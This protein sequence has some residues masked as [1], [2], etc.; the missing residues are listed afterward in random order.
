MSVTVETIA[1][2]S[3]V[4]ASRRKPSPRSI[5]K[6]WRRFVSAAT[7]SAVIG[8]GLQPARCQ[9]AMPIN[10]SETQRRRFTTGSRMEMVHS[11]NKPG[12]A[13]GKRAVCH[14]N[15]VSSAMAMRVRM[16]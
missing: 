2:P 12:G 11:S 5:G 6:V 9:K 1:W 15:V 4:T 8:E 7:Y 3:A 13:I 10:T 14:H 16:A